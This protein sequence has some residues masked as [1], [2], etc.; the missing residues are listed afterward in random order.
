MHQYYEN[1]YRSTSYPSVFPLH[2][3]VQKLLVELQSEL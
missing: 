3:V 1:E 2:R